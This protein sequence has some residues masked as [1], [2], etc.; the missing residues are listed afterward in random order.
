MA[1]RA[2]GED[3]ELEV[4]SL[5][6]DLVQRAVEHFLLRIESKRGR[7]VL[8]DVIDAGGERPPRPFA[9]RMQSPRIQQ[10]ITAEDDAVEQVFEPKVGDKHRLACRSFCRTDVVLAVKAV[11]VDRAR[12][13]AHAGPCGI[14]ISAALQ[15]AVARVR[16]DAIWRHSHSAP[17][18]KLNT[19]TS[20]PI[21][22]DN[23]AAAL[24]PTPTVAR[25]A[26][27]APSRTPQPPTEIGRP[28]SSTT[29]GISIRKST[30]VTSRFCARPRH[31]AVA[32]IANVEI[33]AR[34]K[35][36]A[37]RRRSEHSRRQF[38][39]SPTSNPAKGM[40][41]PLIRW[42]I[43]ASAGS[44]TS[45]RSATTSET[46]SGRLRASGPTP[47]TAS[48]RITKPMPAKLI[49]RS[50]ST[51]WTIVARPRSP[52]GAKSARAAS[53]PIVPSSQQLKKLAI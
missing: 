38:P 28:D 43:G 31:Q 42:L 34:A 24:A 14:A 29:G 39:A 46:I 52:A 26:I 8:I 41:N 9:Y 50:R 27:M 33:V 22:I 2:A 3:P 6:P 11:H 4:M 37:R 32:E 17:P 25:A 18:G 20:P 40:R 12:I 10:L 30:N 23:I 44:R 13:G 35:A 1:N 45:G 53:P 16:A 47:N 49:T 36:A 5:H 15:G 19:A 51:E 21:W 48:G 7:H